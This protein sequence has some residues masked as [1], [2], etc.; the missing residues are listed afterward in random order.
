VRHPDVQE[1]EVR[2]RAPD[3]RKD[4]RSRL[5]LA[6]DLEVAIGL[7]SPT[8]AVENEAMVVS[9]DD[10]HPSSVAQGAD[11]RSVARGWV[12]P[13]RFDTGIWG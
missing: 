10:S 1:H 11:D 4:L 12:V 8:D 3:E 9:D 13:D 2:L 7:E 5:R 6:D